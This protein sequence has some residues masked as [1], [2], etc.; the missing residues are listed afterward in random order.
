M[1]EKHTESAFNT[2][3]S[4]FILAQASCSSPRGSRGGPRCEALLPFIVLI[5]QGISP[6]SFQY[7]KGFIHLPCD[8]TRDFA[9]LPFDFTGAA[10]SLRAPRR[11]PGAR[12]LLA[13]P[14]RHVCRAAA[15]RLPP[16]YLYKGCPLPPF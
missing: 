5:L 10:L 6:P 16:F 13:V 8:I 12:H 9:P 11:R 2:A 4:V 14:R 7:Y 15:R 3:H 1:R